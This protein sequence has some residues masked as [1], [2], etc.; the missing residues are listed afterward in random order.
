MGDEVRTLVTCI[1]L[2]PSYTNIILRAWDEIIKAKNENLNIVGTVR[3]VFN[4]GL[5]VDIFGLKVEIENKWLSSLEIQDA[6]KYFDRN[7]EL[8]LRIE[9]YDQEHNKVVLSNV[10]TESDPK[11]ILEEFDDSIDVPMDGIVKKILVS[12]DGWETGILIE[13]PGKSLTGYIPRRYVTYSRFEK[14]SNLYIPDS[15][16]KVIR[17]GFDA[18]FK[19]LTCK[20]YELKDPWTPPIHY[21]VD[22]IVK[23][24]IRQISHRYL[25]VEL[26]PGLEGVIPLSEISWGQEEQKKQELDKYKILQEVSAKII[27]INFA[28]RQILL[29]FKRLTHSP[30]YDFYELHAGE[31]VHG[32]VTNVNTY[33]CT[34][35]LEPQG[36]EAYMHASEFMWNNCG[37]MKNSIRIGDRLAVKMLNYDELYDNIKVSRKRAY[38]N[39]Y[40]EFVKM[41]KIGDE[42]A[43]IFRCCNEMRVIFS[44]T[45]GQNQQ[46]EGYVHKSEISNLIFIDES[47]IDKIFLPDRYY[48]FIVKRIDDRFRIVELSRKKYLKEQIKTIK[49]GQTYTAVAISYEG[50]KIFFH[51]E[52]LEGFAVESMKGKPPLGQICDVIPARIDQAYIELGIV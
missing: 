25:I 39:N 11:H 38:E 31:I 4:S 36:I 35:A 42:V 51:G 23:A 30:T 33:N 48:H 50:T 3:E 5:S 28:D 1:A 24:V 43:G 46:V 6:R 26:L 16:I 12:G 34:L 13:F 21:K 17:I 2:R 14:L 40:D 19:T 22:Q 45:L 44:I 20:I 52:E 8:S 15:S 47:N 10:D 7:D 49:Y 37:N 29:S 9:E 41:Y 32:I 27:R 18:R